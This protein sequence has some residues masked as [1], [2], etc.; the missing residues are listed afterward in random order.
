MSEIKP[1]DKIYKSFNYIRLRN[2][3][4]SFNK[5]EVKFCVCVVITDIIVFAFNLNFVGWIMD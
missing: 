1:E 3:T 2:F 4:N 5:Y